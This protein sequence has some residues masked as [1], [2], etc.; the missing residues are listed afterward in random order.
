LRYFRHLSAT[1][2]RAGLLLPLGLV[3]RRRLSGRK[4][5]TCKRLHH[6]KR[7][8]G[9]IADVSSTSIRW[10]MAHTCMHLR[11]GSAAT[12]SIDWQPLSEPW[13]DCVKHDKARRGSP[14]LQL[15]AE[16]TMPCSLIPKSRP[17]YREAQFPSLTRGRALFCTS[18][19]DSC[20]GGSTVPALLC[21]LLHRDRC[22]FSTDENLR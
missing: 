8:T 16:P 7:E 20:Y 9:A 1:P 6:A 3:R 17:D 13:G 4:A 11:L 12:H 19:T 18:Y 15:K 21:H 2:T 14:W 5:A 10:L 22:D